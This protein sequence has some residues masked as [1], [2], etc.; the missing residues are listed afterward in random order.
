MKYM[1]SVKQDFDALLKVIWF[2]FLETLTFNK[3]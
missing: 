2:D 3:P 1:Q